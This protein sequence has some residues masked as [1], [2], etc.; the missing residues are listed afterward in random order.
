MVALLTDRENLDIFE[1]L[2]WSVAFGIVISALV[3]LLI[4]ALNLSVRFTLPFTASLVIL[5][6][7]FDVTKRRQFARRFVEKPVWLDL[8]FT[9]FL[10]VVFV[11][12]LSHGADLSFRGDSWAHVA[13]VDEVVESGQPLP[14]DPYRPDL[15]LAHN[16]G[17]WHYTMAVIAL[18]SDVDVVT[19]IHLLNLFIG[20][21]VLLAVYAFVRR[22]FEDKVVAVF[23]TGLTLL[24]YGF[25]GTSTFEGAFYPAVVNYGLMFLSIG[26]YYDDL[27]NGGHWRSV[28]LSAILAVISF[29]LHPVE[30]F[31]IWLGIG[32]ITVVG[33]AIVRRRFVWSRFL[34]WGGLTLIV[35]LP[36]FFSR[37]WWI[38]RRLPTSQYHTYVGMDAGLSGAFIVEQ[39]LSTLVGFF[40][41]SHQLA[42][43]L[44]LL[45]ILYGLWRSDVDRLPVASLAAL[46]MGPFLAILLFKLLLPFT[47]L[48]HF[49]GRTRLLIPVP[50]VLAYALHWIGTKR[51]SWSRLKV[52]LSFSIVVLSILPLGFRFGE[53][54]VI[55]EDTDSPFSR[56]RFS[57]LVYE[58]E[59]RLLNQLCSDR[60]VILS[61]PLTSYAVPGLTHQHVVENFWS[62]ANKYKG[63]VE[64]RTREIYRLFNDPYQSS[65][66]VFATLDR[67]AVDCVVYA[68]ASYK[69][70]PLA[71]SVPFYGPD[72]AVLL[73]ENSHVFERLNE[74]DDFA[75]YAYHS[76]RSTNITLVGKDEPEISFSTLPDP[77]QLVNYRIL[78]SIT[79][80]GYDI[81][82]SMV[83]P[84]DQISITL[85]WQVE[86]SMEYEMATF[87]SALCC[88]EEQSK[89][90]PIRKLW[91]KLRE[92]SSGKVYKFNYFSWLPFFGDHGQDWLAGNRFLTYVTLSVP[93][94]AVPGTYP[95]SLVAMPR[96]EFIGMSGLHGQPWLEDEDRFS[97][98]VI[99]SIQVIDR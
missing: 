5:F 99:T 17:F 66:E 22:L 12:L 97:S 65:A 23:A 83:V 30:W 71:Q 34:V 88:A 48:T 98:I 13:V 41:S 77:T 68:P 40:P 63:D 62:H 72:S 35:S 60:G 51:H 58:E 9:L 11:L 53:K 39:L 67:W 93:E 49:V 95:V 54:F 64:R 26:L 57:P 85:T 4:E 50:V 43:Y 36:V 89:P 24:W 86:R 21:F 20:L 55:P 14:S 78:P 6:V 2:A 61:D 74:K 29:M 79:L 46:V 59:Y 1:A 81:S 82:S 96:Y 18:Y 92:V 75:I 32:S 44:A 47:S 31:I 37:Y 38:F 45:I 87:V 27:S 69:R 76:P 16:Y 8:G 94:N 56:Q 90:V 42:F 73:E 3:G 25:M 52:W 91:R 10:V 19:V 84:G 28:I 80:V 33:W 70:Y 15:P 7:V